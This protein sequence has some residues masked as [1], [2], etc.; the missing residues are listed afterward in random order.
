ML[1]VAYQRMR[2][3]SGEIYPTVYNVRLRVVDG[4]KL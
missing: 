3:R 2:S 1:V 4:G